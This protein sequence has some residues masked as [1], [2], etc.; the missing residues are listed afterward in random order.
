MARCLDFKHTWDNKGLDGPL[1]T[2]SPNVWTST[3][4]FS[5][6]SSALTVNNMPRPLNVFFI[7]R[8]CPI[9]SNDLVHCLMQIVVWFSCVLVASPDWE[10]WLTINPEEDFE[11]LSL[12]IFRMSQQRSCPSSDKPSMLYSGRTFLQVTPQKF[13]TVSRNRKIYLMLDI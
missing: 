3:Q 8:P 4:Q 9:F 1:Q 12:G 2:Q 5:G 7:L 6:T 10:C 13:K 11:S